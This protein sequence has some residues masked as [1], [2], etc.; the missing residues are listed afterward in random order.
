MVAEQL[1]ISDDLILI[2]VASFYLHFLLKQLLTQ[3]TK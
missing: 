3:K 1:N 2:F